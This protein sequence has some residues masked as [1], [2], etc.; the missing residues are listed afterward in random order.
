[1]IYHILFVRSRAEFKVADELAQIGIEP[2]VPEEIREW[3]DA[4]GRPQSTRLALLSGYVVMGVERSPDW[5]A[6]RDIDGV[7]A[8]LYIGPNLAVVPP[9]VVCDL[10]DLSQRVAYDKKIAAAKKLVRAGQPARIVTGP[11][12]GRE[13]LVD[14]IRGSEARIILDIIGKATPTWV[15]MRNLEAA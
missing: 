8:P 6:I 14:R 5:R 10:A 12:A 3:Q 9:R 15:P 13:S 2:V 1:V 4:K 7:R 11:L